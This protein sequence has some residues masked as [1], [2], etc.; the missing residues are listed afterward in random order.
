VRIRKK[1]A[2]LAIGIMLLILCIAGAEGAPYVFGSKVQSGDSDLTRSLN[3]MPAGTIFAFW[4]TGAPGYDQED[5]VYLHVPK[6]THSSDLYVNDNDVRLIPYDGHAA[7]S[8]VAIGDDDLGKPLTP[9][10][11]AVVRYMDQYGSTGYDL[12]D[13]VYIHQN[14]NSPGAFETINYDVRLTNVPAVTV[15]ATELAGTKIVDLDPDRNKLLGHTPVSL[16]PIAYY[17]KNGN[18]FYDDNDEVYLNYPDGG[19]SVK[20]NNV[21]LT[22][23]A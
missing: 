1:I 16:G 4:D 12:E 10:P 3:P 14:L 11:G 13:P 5:V 17:D 20:I 18:G 2:L 19:Y 23:V 8:N 21:R 7:G 22:P 6:S 9:L 15:P